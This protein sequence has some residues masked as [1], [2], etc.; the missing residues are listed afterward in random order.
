MT[1]TDVFTARLCWEDIANLDIV[2]GH[3]D[4]VDEQLDEL[5]ALLERRVGESCSDA[6][7]EVI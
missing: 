7:A 3:H 1:K 2:I 5:A 4:P 6:L